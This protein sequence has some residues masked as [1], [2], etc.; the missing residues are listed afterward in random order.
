[1]AANPVRLHQSHWLIG[2]SLDIN[3]LMPR[4]RKEST[5]RHRTQPTQERPGRRVPL[6]AAA[7][8]G[9]AAD[10]ARTA[11]ESAQES[12][13]KDGQDGEGQTARSLPSVPSPRQPS[14]RSRSRSRSRPPRSRSPRPSRSRSPRPP[15]SRSERLSASRRPP[16]GADARQRRMPGLLVT[17]WFAAAAGFVIAAALALNSPHTVLTYRPNTQLCRI[18]KQATPQRGSLATA[19]PGVRLKPATPAHGHGGPKTLGHGSAVGLG[20]SFRVVW[21][22]DGSFGAIITVPAA[23]AR[24]GWSLRFDIPGTRITQVWGAQ[25]QPAAGGRGGLASMSAHTEPPGSSPPPGGP[26]RRKHRW[27]GHEPQSG[28]A[29]SQT[30]PGAQDARFLVVAS[31]SPVTPVGCVLNRVV[32]HFS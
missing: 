17:P 30:Q 19:A 15:G 1:M 2:P 14:S 12:V 16:A 26:G 32:C 4:H 10:A 28:S 3:P 21:R 8:P 22:K 13:R 31:G 6:S 29:G 20:I 5:P 18:C 7:E 25:W 23:Q 9:A 24:R 11:P 27:P